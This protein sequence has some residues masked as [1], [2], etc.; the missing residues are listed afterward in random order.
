MGGESTVLSSDLG[1][2]ANPPPVQGLRGYLAGLLE[3]GFRWDEVR[4]MAATTPAWL[5]G[6]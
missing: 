2:A 3:L 1:Q 6:L 5:L 4:R